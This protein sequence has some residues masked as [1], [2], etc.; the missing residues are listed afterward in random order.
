MEIKV[1]GVHVTQKNRV[2]DVMN[3]GFLEITKR[4]GAAFVMDCKDP[5]RYL[6]SFVLPTREKQKAFYTELARNGIDA[7]A[8]TEPSFMP[9]SYIG[10]YVG[11]DWLEGGEEV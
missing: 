3:D 4:H 11:R 5:V 9:E 2:S 1:Y 7:E 10:R 8:D 6:A